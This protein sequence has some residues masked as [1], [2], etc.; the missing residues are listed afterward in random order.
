M[1]SWI[2]FAAFLALWILI[3]KWLLP[4]LGVPT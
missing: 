3:Q 4:K 1:D 2:A